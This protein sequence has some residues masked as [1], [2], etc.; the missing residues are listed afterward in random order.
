MRPERALFALSDYMVSIA[1]RLRTLS[2]R[3]RD[4]RLRSKFRVLAVSD[5]RQQ[6][7]CDTRLT[8]ILLSN[9]RRC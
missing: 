4:A 5:T 9:S 3:L 1:L 6:T 2:S 8:P 7:G